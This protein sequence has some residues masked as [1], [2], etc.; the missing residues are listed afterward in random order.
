MET[1]IV[2]AMVA[3]FT[4]ASL[5]SVLLERS[6]GAATPT[7]G[8]PALTQLPLVAP[9]EEAQKLG[10]RLHRPGIPPRMVF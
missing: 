8:T 5:G 10:W 4:R 6:K 3:V 7:C 9:Q 2:R 1:L